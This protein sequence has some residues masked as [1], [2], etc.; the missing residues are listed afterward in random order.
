MLCDK[1]G[2]IETH[3]CDK[4]ACGASMS[5]LCNSCFDKR[6]DEV[7]APKMKQWIKDM[8]I[9]KI[10]GTIIF[11]QLQLQLRG[12]GVASIIKHAEKTIP[13]L[14]GALNVLNN[15]K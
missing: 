1:C 2:A 12:R 8:L 5:L 7:K 6:W 13:E 10:K 4:G 9:H 3:P 15:I 14:E 11:N